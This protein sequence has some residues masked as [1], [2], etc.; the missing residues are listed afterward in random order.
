MHIKY[1]VLFQ[2]VQDVLFDQLSFV[3]YVSVFV[4]TFF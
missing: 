2:C 3:T 1:L 4:A